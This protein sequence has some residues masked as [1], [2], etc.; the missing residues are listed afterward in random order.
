VR[1]VGDVGRAEREPLSYALPNGYPS[2]FLI[3]QKPVDTQNR[4]A[5]SEELVFFEQ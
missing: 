5:K 4:A 2:V 3:T 1:N